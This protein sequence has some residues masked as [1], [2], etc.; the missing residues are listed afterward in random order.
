LSRAEAEQEVLLAQI[1]TSQGPS[2]LTSLDIAQLARQGISDPE[3]DLA[4]DLMQHR[5]LRL[6]AGLMGRTMGFYSKKAIH[7]LSSR[8]ILAAF[9]DGHISGHMLLEY[10]VDPGGKIR[11]RA[12]AA[13]LD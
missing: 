10:R 6:Y 13:Y 12:L 8:W 1:E 3:A 4:S 2:L 5:E 11:W 9:E 7:I